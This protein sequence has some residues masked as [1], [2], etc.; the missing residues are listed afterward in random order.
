MGFVVLGAVVVELRVV[1]V[2]LGLIGQPRGVHS[3][4]KKKLLPVLGSPFCFFSL[5]RTQCTH[6]AI[7][8]LQCIYHRA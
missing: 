2:H 1:E 5:L 7:M 8:A 3:K 4:S 6:A